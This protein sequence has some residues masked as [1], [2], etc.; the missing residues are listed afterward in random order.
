MNI[1]EL[2]W[3][4]TGDEAFG[5]GSDKNLLSRTLA[6]FDR[7]NSSSKDFLIADGFREAADR[8]IATLEE[9]KH[10][11]NADMLVFPVAYLYRHSI[12]LMLKQLISEGLSLHLLDDCESLQAT[13]RGHNLSAL[14]KHTR[15]AIEGFWPNSERAD[16][17]AT[18]KTILAFDAL[19]RSGQAFRY[20]KNIKGQPNLVDAPAQVELRELRR[21]MTGVFNLL[22]GCLDAFSDA[23][24]NMLDNYR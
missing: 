6:R 12:E 2:S 10:F 20:G 9:E 24:S 17:E 4:S 14:W 13:L 5:P 8:I 22:G 19:D 11:H 7:F 18:E 15:K 16:L 23:L 21:V 1:D 3:P